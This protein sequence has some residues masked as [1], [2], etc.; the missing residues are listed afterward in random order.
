MGVT[1]STIIAVTFNDSRSIVTYWL[2]IDRR[3]FKSSDVILTSIKLTIH[4]LLS[5]YLGNRENLRK[6]TTSQ[7]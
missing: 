1:I 5:C 2:E 7:P 3:F 4:F 6:L